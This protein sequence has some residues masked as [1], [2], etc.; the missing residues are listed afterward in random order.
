MEQMLQRI[1]R[2]RREL[3]GGDAGELAAVHAHEVLAQARVRWR[4]LDRSQRQVLSRSAQELRALLESHEQDLGISKTPELLLARFGLDSFRRGQ[5]EAVTAALRGHDSL[6]VM[7][8]GAGKS[9]CYQLPA[10]AGHGLVIVVS[11]LIALM[12]DQLSKLRDAGV[13]A[14]ML[15]SGMPDGHNKRVLSDIAQG[16][17]RLVF[18]A[19]ERFASAEFC[20]ALTSCRVSLFV[21]DEAHCVAEWGHDFRPDYLRL[22]KAIAALGH[23]PIM[24]VTATA[25][26][27]VASEIAERLGLREWVHVSSGFDRPNLTFDVANVEDL[28]TS[29]HKRTILFKELQKAAARPA[30]VYCGTR[31]ETE[32]VTR[33]LTSEGL[34]A[35][36]YHAGMDPFD[37][38]LAQTA[39]MQGRSDIVVATTAFGMGVDKADVRTVVHWSIPKSLEAYYHEVGRAGRDE[40]QA[41]ALLLASAAD[42][43]R[44]FRLHKR[45]TTSV[46]DVQIYLASLKRKA[47]AGALEI[48]H[49]EQEERLLLSVAERAG[50][51]RLDPGEKNTLKATL[52]GKFDTR[53]AYRALEHAKDRGRHAYRSIEL[54][55]SSGE[56]RRRQILD[57]F[58]DDSPGSPLG[59]CCDVC[60]SS[61]SQDSRVEAHLHSPAQLDRRGSRSSPGLASARRQAGDCSSQRREPLPDPA[62]S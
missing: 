51:V 52:T 37:R 32:S 9:L 47:C 35:V 62:T 21:V 60:G 16:K 61:V 30:I 19:P 27:T 1:E 13:R 57:F 42:L 49:L 20:D 4:H 55:V 40:K 44:L 43:R 2:S 25:T 45:Q 31:K 8:T 36:T 54:F 18:A 22:H 26:R 5:R 17:M 48:P 12:A 56:C 10:L 29:D 41:R 53:I 14:C 3:R 38:E 34:S 28:Q 50:A 23:P 58:G 15:A 59:R 7:P 6:I 11:P 24:A 33:M 39:F 46:E